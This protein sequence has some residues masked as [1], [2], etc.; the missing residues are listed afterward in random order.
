LHL[1][2]TFG[3][4][5]REFQ[6]FG[7][8][9][10]E[11][12]HCEVD[13]EN[14]SAGSVSGLAR[15]VLVYVTGSQSSPDFAVALSH[16][17]GIASA[18]AAIVQFDLRMWNADEIISLFPDQRSLRNVLLQ[19]LLDLSPHNLPE[20]EIVLFD[21]QNHNGIVGTHPSVPRGRT[22]ASPT[23]LFF[24]VSSGED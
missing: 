7:Q 14:V 5:A 23:P 15:A 8:N 24:R 18:V 21:V 4:D 11:L 17:S 20:P 13:F 19:V 9:L 12:I 22:G 10:R 1:R 6:L 2:M 3:L 16:A